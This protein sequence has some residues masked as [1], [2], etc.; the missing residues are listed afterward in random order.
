[1]DTNLRQVAS[2]FSAGAENVQNDSMRSRVPSAPELLMYATPVVSSA[3]AAVSIAALLGTGPRVLRDRPL[4]ASLLAAFGAL[5]FAKSQFDRFITEQP[6]YERERR[7][8]GLE[9]RRYAS[10][11]VAETTIET[12]DFDRALD[13]GFRRLAGFIFGGNR[14][15]ARLA[16]TSPVNAATQ[17]KSIVVRFQMPRDSSAPTPT[18]ARVRVR[19]VD[20]ERVATLIVRGRYDAEHVPE[21]ARELLRRVEAAGLEPV[22]PVTFAGYDS[23]ATLPFL[24]R[25]EMWVAVR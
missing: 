11:W 21:G 9:I 25:T 6:R 8:G 20:S 4:L 16:M 15:R 23:P 24:R 5:V 3:L 7:I 18:D 2:P 10:R 14:E 19:K 1:M 22:G 13:E 17:G 12:G